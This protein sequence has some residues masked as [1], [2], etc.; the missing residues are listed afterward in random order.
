[1]DIFKYIDIELLCEQYY[2]E[3]KNDTVSPK[4]F[5]I[6]AEAKT[7][8]V[9]NSDWSV[10]VTPHKSDFI[11][12]IKPVTKSTNGLFSTARVIGQGNFMHDKY[13]AT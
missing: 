3:I 9:F 6:D 12:T 5:Y 8:I 1:M 11:G 7:P 4:E 13:G 10:V 2:T